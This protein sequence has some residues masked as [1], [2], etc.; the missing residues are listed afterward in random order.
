MFAKVLLLSFFSILAVTPLPSLARTAHYRLDPANSDVGFAWDF[1]QDEVKGHMPVESA[2]LVI[3]FSDVSRS[4]V[5]V[6][7]NANGAEAGFPFASQAMKGPKVLDTA[8]HPL[9][10]FTSTKVT[11]QGDKARIDGLITIRG[12][13]KP[14]TLIAQLYRPQGSDPDDMSNLSIRLVGSV[15]R[16]AFGA[17]GWPDM[18]GDEVR[19]NILA[20]I[21]EV[22]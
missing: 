18:A 11:K 7:V 22:K 1:G 5:N 12:V 6:A 15:S 20:Y 4:K 13:T 14:A 10:R 17:D 8:N 19:L 16:S 9:I 21:S 3:D 2:D